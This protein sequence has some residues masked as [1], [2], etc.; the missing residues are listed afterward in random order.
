[1]SR[2]AYDAAGRG[3]RMAAWSPP[4][5]GPNTAIVG[6]DLIRERSRD[7]SRNDWSSA[8]ARQ[9]WATNLIGIGI[10]PRFKGVVAEARRKVVSRM[11]EDWT[12][13]CDAD[14]VNTAYGLQTLAVLTWFD[15]GECF[16]RRRRRP[17][18]WG[19]PVPVQVQLLEADMLPFLNA[20][21]YTGLPQ[22]NVIRSGIELDKRGQRVAYWFYKNHPGDGVV[23]YSG[24]ELVRVAASDVRHIYEPKRPGQLRGVAESAPV[25]AHLRDILDYE[26]ATLL[27]QK[28]ANL[29]VGFVTRTTAPGAQENDPL[30]GLPIRGAESDPLVALHP[31]M[32]QELEDGQKVEFGNPPEAGTTYSD[33]MRT[34]H[35][36]TAAGMGLPYELLTGDIK[37]ISDRALRVVIN[38]FRRLCEQRQWQVVIPK[39]CQ[40]MIDWFAEGAVL[41]GA[42]M[43]DEYDSVRRVEHAPHG[44]AHIHP[45]QDPQGKAMEVDNG[46]RS[47]SSVIGE[48]GDDPDQV[49][50]ERAADQERAERFGLPAA[51]GGD[52]GD[53]DGIDNDEYSAP[54]NAK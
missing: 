41:I 35:L 19:L 30:T 20:D 43:L 22:G 17:T 52:K 49:D 33:Y 29:F 2:P 25:L 45:V 40:P 42:V 36:G 18:S 10:R 13:V 26:D 6:A 1:M 9:K 24:Q 16:M 23:A 7:S 46:F 38:E 27:R 34:S 3:R 53:A 47:R 48:R 50:E 32:F 11:F 37:D 28:I 31:G 54:P 39:M 8:S 14:G 5:T 51:P 15:G 12:Q 44:W 21:T 4:R